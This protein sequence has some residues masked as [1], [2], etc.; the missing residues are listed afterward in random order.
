MPTD[1]DNAKYPHTRSSGLPPY[2][3]PE[4]P[5]QVFPHTDP[6]KATTPPV[7]RTSEPLVGNPFFLNDALGKLDS[8]LGNV[9]RILEREET[10]AANNR[11]LR[12]LMD[13]RDELDGIQTGK[14][15]RTPTHVSPERDTDGGLFVD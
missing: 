1:S 13:M 10:M 12:K 8:S 9:I 2:P 6:N 4:N 11:L 7:Q 15:V 5:G 3:C 14:K